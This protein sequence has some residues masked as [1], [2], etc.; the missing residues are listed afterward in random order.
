MVMHT[1]ATLRGV[2]VWHV[3]IVTLACLVL[4]VGG[5][6][7]LLV[8]TFATSIESGSQAATNPNQILYL[9]SKERQSACTDGTY[10][11]M[12]KGRTGHLHMMNCAVVQ[13]L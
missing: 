12:S 7:Q 6:F 11:V 1:Q 4:L 5:S 13:S 2:S 9:S 8:N 10:F 3:R